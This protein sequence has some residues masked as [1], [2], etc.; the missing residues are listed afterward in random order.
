MLS[1]DINERRTICANYSRA[2]LQNISD[3]ETLLFLVNKSTEMIGLYLDCDFA[4][5][6]INRKSTKNFS[7]S[8]LPTLEKKSMIVDYDSEK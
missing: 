4:L 2:N 3:E 8:A 6:G 5:L 7:S 1:S